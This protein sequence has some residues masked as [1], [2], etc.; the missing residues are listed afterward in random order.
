MPALAPSTGIENVSAA[1]SALD[2]PNSMAGSGTG[3]NAELFVFNQVLNV[4][5]TGSLRD[6]SGGAQVAL[7]DNALSSVAGVVALNQAA[8]VAN[9]QGSIVRA[10]AAGN[11]ISPAGAANSVNVENQQSLNVAGQI[12]AVGSGG[13]S[14]SIGG[15]A[16]QNVTGVVAINQAAGVANQQVS[17]VL[18]YGAGPSS[19]AIG[20]QR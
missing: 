2:S 5:P 20:A 9:Q 1:A 6:A 16:L 10:V 11:G 13:Y 15:N 7:A 14:A 3:S 18:W 19:G 8:G 12:E 17:T 4:A